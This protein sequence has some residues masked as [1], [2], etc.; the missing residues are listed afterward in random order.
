MLAST[1]LYSRYAW[2]GLW[3]LLYKSRLET[4][5][6]QIINC[7]VTLFGIDVGMQPVKMLWD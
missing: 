2:L 1:C 4:S 6:R 5:I 3:Q 7:N